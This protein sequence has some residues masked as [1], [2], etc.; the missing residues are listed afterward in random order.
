MK[1]PSEIKQMAKRI[2]F[3]PNEDVDDRIV[4]CAEAAMD[5][6]EETK[7][8]LTRP[9]A[10]SRIMRSRV[11]KIV[12]AALIVVAV[13]IAIENFSGSVDLVS[14]SKAAPV[15]WSVPT[16]G[17]GHYYLPIATSYPI[18]WADANEVANL[19]GGHLATITSMEENDFVFSLIDDDIYWYPSVNIRGPW[20]GG[21][22]LP[23]SS[24]PDGGWAWVTGELFVYTNWDLGQPN[25]Y[26]GHGRQGQDENRIHFGNKKIRV[27]TWN[28]VAL[29][30][31][32]ISAYVVEL[33]EPNSLPVEWPIADGGNG[34]MYLAVAAPAGI[35]WV[36][37][38]SAANLAGGYLA[39]ITSAEE[40]DFVFKLIGDEKYWAEYTLGTSVGPWIGGYQLPGSLEPA[41][42]WQWVI[43]EPFAYTNWGQG[44]PDNLQIEGAD[45]NCLH[46]L[47]LGGRVP[48]VWNDL[49]HDYAGVFGYVIEFFRGAE[50]IAGDLE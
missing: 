41:G 2:R 26:Q 42:S 48:V 37:A 10:W 36:Q 43:Y 18:S 15:K 29:D 27:P 25:N 13:I 30:F 39:T 9:N 20:I 1:S 47:R 32:E 23:G 11:N 35:T 16:G 4:A 24:E 33:S 38:N 34:H 19:L 7:S 44:K 45:E 50:D 14:L 17:N 21:Y 3:K 22:Q 28:D 31:E 49:P 5:R 12:A 6:S 8:P 46:F 40:N